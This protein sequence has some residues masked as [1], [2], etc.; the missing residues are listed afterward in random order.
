MFKLPV[1]GWFLSLVAAISLA[2]PFWIC[3][4]SCGIGAKYFYFLPAVYQSI[5]FWNCVGLFVTLNIIGSLINY[6]TP[7]IVSV[8]N[9]NDSNNGKK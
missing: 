1:I 5:S 6:V 3:W 9:T 8:T 7:R 4:T 2:I